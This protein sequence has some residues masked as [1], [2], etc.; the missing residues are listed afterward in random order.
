MA[1]C[2]NCFSTQHFSRD[3][4]E[5]QRSTRCVVCENVCTTKNSHKGWCPNYDFVS[6]LLHSDENVLTPSIVLEMGFTRV[7]NVFVLDRYVE[8]PIVSTPLIVQNVN[9]MA[10]KQKNR[11]VVS[12]IGRKNE[13]THI[14]LLD[15]DNNLVMHIEVSNNATIVNDRNCIQ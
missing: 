13:V 1:K 15:S 8:K 14:N 5:S 3:C 9:I 12:K 6:E 11:L 10:Q 2:F 7:N 4:T